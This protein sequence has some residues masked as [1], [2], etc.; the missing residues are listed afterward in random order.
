MQAA[1]SSRALS[2]DIPEIT[3]CIPWSVMVVGRGPVVG[4]IS[5]ES[6]VSRKSRDR[7]PGTRSEWRWDEESEGVG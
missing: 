2:D 7:P 3:R 5:Y 6:D 4:S 1:G